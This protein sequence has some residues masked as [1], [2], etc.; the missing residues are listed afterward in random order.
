MPL[1]TQEMRTSTNT[2]T[3]GWTRKG[4]LLGVAG[5]GLLGPLAVPGIASAQAPTPAEPVAAVQSVT[6]APAVAPAAASTPAPAAQP[7]A[8]YTVKAG[9]TIAR[10]AKAQGMRWDTLAELNGV[11]SPFVIYPGQV[12][13]LS[14]SPATEPVHTS[15][16]ERPAPAAAA[17]PAPAAAAAPAPAAVAAASS[18]RAATAVAH[19]LAQKNE[20]DRYVYGANGPSSW[21]CSS[22]TQAAWAKAGVS[23]P[24]TSKAQASAGTATSR[25]SLVPGDLVVY[26]SP[27]S[28]VAM[29]IGNGQVVQ[30]LNS[31]AGLKVTNIDYAG[32]VTGYRHIG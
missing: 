20:G 4:V 31:N 9:D 5:V 22:L 6:P 3:H 23:L 28:H 8:T 13:K 21:D 15:R 30:A 10:I 16:D 17:A 29:Y 18:S 2:S 24:R 19:A 14:G 11:K 12:L 25:A 1:A 27:V 26:F 7:S 32:K